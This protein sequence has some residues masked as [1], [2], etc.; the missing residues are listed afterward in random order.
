LGFEFFYEL[1]EIGYVVVAEEVE[2]EDFVFHDEVAEVA[3]GVVFAGV[4]LAIGV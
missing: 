3:A 4:A 2:A 1:C